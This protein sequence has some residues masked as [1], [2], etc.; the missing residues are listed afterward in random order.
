MTL[1]SRTRKFLERTFARKKLSGRKRRTISDSRRATKDF[2]KKVDK[3]SK[4]KGEK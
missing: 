2:E 1:S 3:G 4:K